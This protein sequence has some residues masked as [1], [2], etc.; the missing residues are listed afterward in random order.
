MA[1][2]LLALLVV[3][4]ALQLTAQEPDLE[5]ELLAELGSL[6][7]LCVEGFVGLQP[8]AGQAREMAIA[9]LF[10]S[11]RF[12]ITENCE[13]ADAIVKGSVTQAKE[14]RSRAEAEST[15]F[16]VAAGYGSASVAGGSGSA[17]G[18]FGAVEG[19]SSE[20]LAS[21]ETISQATITLRIVNDDGDILWAHAEEAK[22]GKVKGP[23]AFAMDRAVN[24]LIREID[25]ARRKTNE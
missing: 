20:V 13:K 14:E 6:R 4:P 11:K 23:V 12:R 24:K 9:G 17:S 2:L 5:A 16:G 19:G 10:E 21:T 18:G 1:R 15:D 7:R 25:R 8:H 3:F 22:E